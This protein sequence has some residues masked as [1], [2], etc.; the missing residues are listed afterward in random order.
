M[1][2]IE[3]TNYPVIYIANYRVGSSATAATLLD[4]GARQINHHHGLPD[5]EDLIEGALIVQGVRHHCDAIVSNYYTKAPTA[6]IGPYVSMIC[7]GRH[8]YLRPPKLYD[9]YPCNYVLRFE[10]LQF[11]FDILCEAAGLPQTTLKVD[12]S[13]RPPDTLWKKV[14][15]THMIAEVYRTFEEEMDFFGYSKT[16]ILP[17]KKDGTV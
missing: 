6:K 5:T 3:G 9:R 17:E 14:L 12:P 15:Q 7:Q 2:V 4:M 16:G 8:R 11:E 1:Y 13:R 10:T